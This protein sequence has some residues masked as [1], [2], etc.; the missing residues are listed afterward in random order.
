MPPRG[1]VARRRRRPRLVLLRQLGDDA[2]GREEQA[3]DGSR[4][5]Q[6]AAGHLGRVDDAGLDEVL[7]FAG[8]DVVAFV[9][10]ALLDFAA[11]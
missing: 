2:L 9:A 6:R 10:F 7:V 1:A 5:L 8:G 11:R 4:V 3:G